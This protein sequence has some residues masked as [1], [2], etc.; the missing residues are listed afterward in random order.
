MNM[1]ELRERMSKI[2]DPRH[3]SYVKHSLADILIIIMCGVLSGLD[4]LG[5]LV[6]YAK[7]KQEFLLNVLEVRQIPSKATFAR[8]LNLVDGKKIGEAILDILRQRFGTAG[9]VIA[10]CRWESNLRDSKAGSTSYCA[11]NPQ[12]L[13]NGKRRSP[14]SGSH[15]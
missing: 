15:S 11:S 13:Y 10:R 6:I 2:E 14:G 4:T 8:V 7:S 5:D 12:R 9:E 3:Q 1:R